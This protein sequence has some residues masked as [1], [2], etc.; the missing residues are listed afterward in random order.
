MIV[1]LTILLLI[2][3]YLLFIIFYNFYKSKFKNI[4]NYPPYVIYLMS[5]QSRTSPFSSIIKNRKDK[6]LKSYNDYCLSLIGAD[7]HTT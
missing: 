4:Q 6:I 5:G 7:S 3:I 1:I 2:I